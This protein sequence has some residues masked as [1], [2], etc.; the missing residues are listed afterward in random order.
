M[1]VAGG[2]AE[3]TNRCAQSAF[4]IDHVRVA[5]IY[6]VQHAE[7]RHLPGDPGLTPRGHQQALCVAAALRHRRIDA[8][9]CS[10]L[11][12][13]QQTAMPIGSA[14]SL[15]VVL[16]E[17]LRER[18]NWDGAQPLSEFIDDWNRCT[19]DRSYVPRSGESSS[20]AAD[21][22]LAF[23]DEVSIAH[24]TVAVV[25]HGGVTVDLLRSLL[26]D[27][28]TPARLLSDG[29]P[30]GAIATLVGADVRAIAQVDHLEG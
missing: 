9:H 5:V 17:R 19:V 18:M 1:L 11:V 13:A 15:P 29:V 10:P 21:R 23:L 7:K 16:D 24:D 14:C 22:L 28:H 20:A 6:L 2:M 8:L 30:P 27:P 4:V 25:T 3:N 12:R 26:G